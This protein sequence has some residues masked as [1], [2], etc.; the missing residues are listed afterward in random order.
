MSSGPW[1]LFIDLLVRYRLVLLLLAFAL[2]GLSLY[3]ASQ[4]SFEQSIESLY[5]PGN[6]HLLEYVES[7]NLFGGDEFVFLTYTDPELFEESGQERLATLAARVTEVPG[8]VEDSVQ[9]LNTYLDLTS[10][11][12]FRSRRQRVLEFARGVL[13]GDDNQTTAIAMRLVQE[14]DAV[15]PRSATIA[16]LR[17]IA[18][19]QSLPTYVVG[20][21]T[22]VLDMFRYAQEDGRFMGLAASALLAVVILFFLRDARSI[23]LPFLIVQM[24][25]VWTKAALWGSHLQLTM[26]SSVLDSLVTIIGVSTVVYLSFY[27]QELSERFD[28]ETAFR[29]MLQ[30][31][32]MDIVWV[33]LTTAAGFAAHFSSHLHPVRSFGLTMVMGSLL[34][35]L[36]IALVLPQGMLAG[37]RKGAP[38]KP[39]GEREVNK[40]LHGLTLWVLGHPR[41]I[42]V[43]TLIALCCGIGGLVQLRL[44]TDFSANFRSSSP[45]VKSLTFME[46]RLGGAGIWEVN[47]SAPETLDEDQLTKVRRLAAKLRELRIG[48]APALTKVVAI[49]D[50]LDL[51]PRIPILVPDDAARLRWMDGLQPEFGPS[52]FNPEKGHMRIMLRARERQSAEDKEQLIARVTEVARTEF[53]DAQATGLF[54]LLTYLV[55]SLLR[56]QWTGLVVGGISLVAMMSIAYRSVW[57]GLVS[58]V[59]NVLPIILLLG[60]MG[61]SGIP[62]NIGT[63]MISSDT[64]GLTIHDSIFYLSAYQRARHS[65]LDFRGALSEV[66]SEVR[67]PLIYSNLALIVGFLVLTTSHFVPLIY[68]GALV[69]T[70]IAGGLIVNLL[71]IPLL[72]QLG[73]HGK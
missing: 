11:G 55:E 54:V 41:G 51:V 58:L 47:F 42:A 24:T 70:A 28:R 48:S 72:L 20:E 52:L 37:A 56:D 40:F 67:R 15:Q 22:L 7:K 73:E 60:A 53:P 12:A 30:V 9:S 4:V 49:T 23:L 63:A 10:R 5:S 25:I 33:C 6:P 36:A 35:L 57:L 62:I 18:A 32:G 17:R 65:G 1:N 71:L 21:P 43:A 27:F 50:G 64:M 39:R 46:D 66:Q 61:W 38:T 13:L 3:P 8:V 44:E 31:I 34:V 19:E 69:S 2:T 14:S 26:V 29:K 59:P 45:V 16:E 68:F